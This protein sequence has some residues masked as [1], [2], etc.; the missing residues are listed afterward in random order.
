MGKES[1]SKEVE[2]E[3]GGQL[4]AVDGPCHGKRLWLVRLLGS[5]QITA[6]SS[7]SL[8][9]LPLSRHPIL[10]EIEAGEAKLSAARGEP[11]QLC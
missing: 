8:R 2:V 6:M 4:L 3:R 7:L 5:H 9:Q 10:R 11:H 1:R